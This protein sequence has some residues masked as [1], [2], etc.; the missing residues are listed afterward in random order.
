MIQSDLAYRFPSR[1]GNFVA[2]GFADTI[3]FALP[4]LWFPVFTTGSSTGFRFVSTYVFFGFW[5]TGLDLGTPDPTGMTTRRRGQ[6][7][8]ARLEAGGATFVGV[9]V[10]FLFSFLAYGS[11]PVHC[12]AFALVF[13]VWVSAAGSSEGLRVV[14][15]VVIIV[16]VG[17]SGFFSFFGSH[18]QLKER[19]F[20]I[21]RILIFGKVRVSVFLTSLIFG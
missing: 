6:F 14:V 11:L 13:F 18:I 7:H 17:V 10:W 8:G 2:V 9:V 20:N 16:E 19:C 5:G 1:R 4:I 3:V 12:Y 21:V 15:Y